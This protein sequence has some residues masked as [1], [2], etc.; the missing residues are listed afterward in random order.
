MG[1]KG[2]EV[3]KKVEEVEN[4][5]EVGLWDELEEVSTAQGEEVK[6]VDDGRIPIGRGGMGGVSGMRWWW[7]VI[8][9]TMGMG[10]VVFIR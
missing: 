9:T 10:F 4:S 1:V 2:P 8:L 6:V 5:V 3:T 7:R